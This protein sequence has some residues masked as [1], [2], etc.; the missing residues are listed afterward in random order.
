MSFG[1]ED[2]TMFEGDMFVCRDP[3]GDS[4]IFTAPARAVSRR[5]LLAVCP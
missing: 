4:R 5:A 2:P 1:A 3:G